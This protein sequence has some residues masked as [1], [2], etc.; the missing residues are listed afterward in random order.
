MFR[1]QH[2]LFILIALLGATAFT[3]NN[4]E[5]IA[6]TGKTAT[7]ATI[8]SRSLTTT[9]TDTRLTTVTPTESTTTTRPTAEPTTSPSATVVTTDTSTPTTA[10]SEPAPTPPRETTTPESTTVVTPSEPEPEPVTEARPVTTTEPTPPVEPVSV[11]EPEPEPTSTPEPTPEPEPTPAATPTPEPETAAAPSPAPTTST[12]PTRTYPQPVYQPTTSVSVPVIQIEPEPEQESGEIIDQWEA[13]AAIPNG[14]ADDDHDGL[15]NNIEFLEKTDPLNPDT[16]GDQLTDSEELIDF[17]TDPLDPNSP[18]RMSDLGIR[19]TSFEKGQIVAD[20]EPFIKG[21]APISSYIQISAINEQEETTILGQTQTHENGIFSFVSPHL[22]DGTYTVLVEQIEEPDII[23]ELFIPAHAQEEQEEKQLISEP[24]TIVIDTSSDVSTPSPKLLDDQEITPEVLM[25]N[26]RIEIENDQP[27]LK[28]N[29]VFQHKVIATWQSV[30]FSSA[31]IADSTAGEFEITPQQKFGTGN[32][33]VYVQ[34][35][36][37]TTGAVSE[38]VRIPFRI[39]HAEPVDMTTEGSITESVATPEV[40]PAAEEN[41]FIQ[42]PVL[43][44]IIANPIPTAVVIGIILLLI[45]KVAKREEESMD[46]DL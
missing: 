20:P 10:E 23:D 36:H 2:I 5:L 25:E 33:E 19:I 14:T 24:V 31:L 16:D 8:P 45:Y 43:A 40:R 29:T 3:S 17:K 42:S 6:D 4:A 41:T 39:V 11:S 13:I 9:T 35:V 46:P 7:T 34:A 21:F 32:H 38:K 12:P 26:L 18:Q 15:S 44:W 37:P 30:V 22:E 27:V 28:G 1:K